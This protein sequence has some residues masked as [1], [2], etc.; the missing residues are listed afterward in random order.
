MKIYDFNELET[1]TLVYGGHSG[2]KLGVVINGENWFLK[3]PKRIKKLTRKFEISYTT[4]PLSEYIGS[5]IYESIGIP[6]HETKLGIKDGKVV[7]ACKDF[8]ENINKIHF[9]DYNSIKN[10]Y[11]DGMEEKLK[12]VSSSSNDHNVSLEEVE[13]LLI[14]HP[15]FLKNPELKQRF[16][17]MFVV[18]AL[19]GNNARN[20]EDWG[21]LVN[22]KTNETTVCPVFDNGASFNTK[23]SDEQIKKIMN[24]NNMFESSVYKSI[25]CIFVVNDKQLNPFKYI[26]SLKNKDCDAAL[27]R[28]VPKINVE[29][30]KK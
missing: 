23:S 1:N 27:M 6:V 22:N 19:I 11:V 29:K 10:D 3:F 25:M 28:I 9:D 17:D 4:S 5:H 7:V 18:D 26:E 30:I 2:Q 24:D 16:W 20:N 12:L 15:L 8:R 21:V 13:V 14:N